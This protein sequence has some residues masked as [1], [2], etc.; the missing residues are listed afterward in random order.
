MPY[1]P[2]T[3]GFGPP[4]TVPPTPMPG[5][6]LVQNI[7]SIM[8]TPATD[9]VALQAKAVQLATCI[10]QY[11]VDVVFKMTTLVPAVVAG[12]V[13]PGIAV[14]AGSPPGPGSTVAPGVVTGTAIIAPGGLK[15][16]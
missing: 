6:T 13:A 1:I 8:S 9:P 5:A 3:S 10:D 15:T 7:M 12:A 11:I 4:T 16:N 2:T 14:V